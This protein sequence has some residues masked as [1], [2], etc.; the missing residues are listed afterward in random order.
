M[1]ESP[2]T[3]CFLGRLRRRFRLATVMLTATGVPASVTASPGFISWGESMG[4]LVGVRPI[5]LL[6]FRPL[7]DLCIQNRSQRGLPFL[8]L[9]GAEVFWDWHLSFAKRKSGIPGFKRPECP[10]LFCIGHLVPADCGDASPR[11]R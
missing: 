10:L 5:G 4:Y 7:F 3:S 1:E 6:E 2:G 9:R 11:F 8:T